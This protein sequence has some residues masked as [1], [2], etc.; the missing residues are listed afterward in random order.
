MTRHFHFCAAWRSVGEV[1]ALRR[2]AA[3]FMK[4]L[5]TRTTTHNS[6]FLQ[7]ENHY[8]ANFFD[9]VHAGELLDDVSFVDYERNGKLHRMDGPASVYSS[10]NKEWFVNNR[11]HRIDGPAI[12]YADGS[13]VW[14]NDG[15]QHR[16]DGPAYEWSNGSKEWYLNGVQMTEAEFTEWMYNIMSVWD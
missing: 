5:L 7:L 14:Y 1:A 9:E 15:K 8:L 2:D 11:L 12:E 4:I 6:S 10:G 3:I 16:T 13:K